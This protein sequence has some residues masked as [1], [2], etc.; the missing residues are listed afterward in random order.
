M[1]LLLLFFIGGQL[2]DSI[3]GGIMRPGSPG[4]V[5]CSEYRTLRLLDGIRASVHAARHRYSQVRHHI[6]SDSTVVEIPD[7]FAGLLLGEVAERFR[8]LPGS[9]QAHLVAVATILADEGAN[10]DLITA[11]LIHD[12]GKSVPGITIHLAARIAKVVIARVSPRATDRIA[13]WQSPPRL[14]KGLWVLCRHP[15]TGSVLAASSGYNER[16]LWLVA[17]HE[18]TELVDPDLIAL[19]VADEVSFP[20]PAR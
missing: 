13:T 19:A 5:R 14:G 10:D 11:G 15:I 8:S 16:V 12:V 20:V 7:R 9:D 2:G 17:N 18:R 1:I 3:V 6:A 4:A